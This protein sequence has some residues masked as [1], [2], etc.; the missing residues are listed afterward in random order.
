MNPVADAIMKDFQDK[1]DKTLEKV[2]EHL[3]SIRA[4]R[5]N[6]GMLDIVMVDYYGTP[7][8]LKQ[9]ANLSTLDAQ[10][11]CIEPWDKSIIKNIEKGITNANL[12]LNPSNDG[13]KLLIK[14]PALTAERRKEYVKMAKSQSEDGKVAIRNLRKDVNN[15]LRKGQKDSEITEDELKSYEDTVQKHTDIY[16]KKIDEI[17]V[18]KEKDINTL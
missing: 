12:G 5:A 16:I 10:T 11:I 8:P 9:A 6:I 1:L 7:T 2:K 4:G 18:I 3:A 17:L 14:I 15:K 13:V